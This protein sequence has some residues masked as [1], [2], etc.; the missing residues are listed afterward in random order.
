MQQSSLAFRELTVQDTKWATP[1]LQAS[2]RIGCEYS[3]TTL[4]MWRKFYH[5]KLAKQGA[6]LFFSSGEKTPSFLPPIGPSLQ[7]GMELLKAHTTAL[8]IPLH[9]HG[10]DEKTYLALSALYPARITKEERPEDF[11]YLYKSKD[12]AELSGKAYHGKRN[13]IAA[14]SR[15][16]DWQYET[17]CDDNVND[18]R[19]LSKQWCKEKGDCQDRGLQQ[20]TCA[21]QEVLHHRREL[22]LN[23]GLIRVAG[24]AVAFTLGSPIN[25][26]VYDIHVEKALS[27]Y[28]TAY[29]VINREFAKTLTEYDY[30]NRENDMGIE[31]LRRAKQSYRPS[32]HLKKLS[33]HINL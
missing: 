7:E 23:G 10:V 2:S 21:I 13:H 4:Y 6:F 19:E 28:A 16:Y 18:I 27:E 8:N 32:I 15:K 17:L 31:G 3:Y 5:V 22:S 24:K 14:F 26:R 1:M 20:E 9:L 29:T 33:C 30:L 25:D 12:L 11:D